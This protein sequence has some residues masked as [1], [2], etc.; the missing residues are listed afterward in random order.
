MSAAETDERLEIER[1]WELELSM[2]A[3]KMVDQ[4]V[5]LL[6]V[7]LLATNQANETS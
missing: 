2:N 1:P 4:V 5:E 6:T 7:E 3:L